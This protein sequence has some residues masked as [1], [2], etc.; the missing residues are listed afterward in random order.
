MKL[1]S[2]DYRKKRMKKILEKIKIASLLDIDETMTENFYSYEEDN[3]IKKHF[4]KNK[5]NFQSI[6]GEIGC[7]LT[8]FSSGANGHT[9]KG[10]IVDEDEKYYIAVKIVP[11]TR[12]KQYCPNGKRK[13]GIL[14]K[15]ALKM[16]NY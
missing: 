6:F 10:C 9:F 12:H 16:Q 1:F 2:I 3:D 4:S 5:E 11:Y 8:F 14:T 15:N 7:K 13:N